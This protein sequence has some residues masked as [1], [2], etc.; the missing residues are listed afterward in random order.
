MEFDNKMKR[1]LFIVG[2]NSMLAVPFYI[3]IVEL[4][5][6]IVLV[7]GAWQAYGLIENYI[8]YTKESID[9]TQKY[10]FVTG[11]DSGMKM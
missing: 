3:Y 1:L 8:L 11:C 2:L 5:L 4:T 7:F 6:F 10:V 9:P